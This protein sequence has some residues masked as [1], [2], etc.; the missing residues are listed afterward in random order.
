MEQTA[1]YQFSQE[2]LKEAKQRILVWQLFL[3]VMLALFTFVSPIMGNNFLI[4]AIAFVITLIIVE[5]ILLIQPPI[6]HKKLQELTLTLSGEAIERTGGRFSEKI[7]YKD[8]RRIDIIERS[9]G[10]IAYIKVQPATGK[11]LYLHSFEGMVGIAQQIEHAVSD[12][13]LLHRKRQAIAWNRPLLQIAIGT[14]TVIVILLIQQLGQ[15]AFDIFISFAFLAWA[16]FSLIFRPITKG[17]G[18]RFEK[19]EISAAVIMLLYA[20]VS[21]ALLPLLRS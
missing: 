8:I 12:N 9:S 7:N 18:K 21:L 2:A 14:L 20:I 13:S 17:A 16:L 1:T 11:A 19:F 3:P 5:G 6:M 10:E 15:N 4:K